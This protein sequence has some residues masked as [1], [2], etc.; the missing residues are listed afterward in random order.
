MVEN[1]KDG[2]VKIIAEGE[3]ERLKWFES[4]IDIRNTLINVSSIDKEYS[5]VGGEFDD[6][7]KL[8]FKGETDTRRDKGVEVMKDMLAGIKDINKALVD[9]NSNLGGKID[10]MNESLSDKI[11]KMNENLSGK[12]DKMNE[13]LSGKMDKSLA[14][15]DRML[16]KQDELLVE[17]KDMNR[18]LNEKIDKVLDKDIVELKAD[19]FEIKAALKAKGII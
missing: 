3:D 7:G 16:E 15:Q 8:V 17:V 18:S 4:A 10:K 13:N 6:F 9:M 1:L 12:I 5:S 19:V 14:K 11:D 2:R